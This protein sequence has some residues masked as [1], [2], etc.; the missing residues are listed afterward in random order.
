MKVRFNLI[1]KGFRIIEAET[2]EE[3]KDIMTREAAESIK[4]MDD[5]KDGRVESIDISTG[6][7]RS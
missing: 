3:A 4:S 5:L 2:I 1:M 6:E 7:V